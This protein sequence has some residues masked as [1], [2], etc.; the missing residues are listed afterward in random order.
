MR[1]LALGVLS[2]VFALVASPA[3]A[4]DPKP[5]GPQEARDNVDKDVAVTMDV[6]ASKHAKKHKRIFLDSEEDFMHENNLGIEITEKG[7]LE[8][9][10]KGISDPAAHFLKK[11][12]RVKGKV[13]T[14]DGRVY[15]DV[16]RP[17][18]IEIVEKK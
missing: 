4:D 18:Q 13:V 14:R 16:D 9:A 6:K 15:I 2:I 10:R 17:E 5:I 11:T 8:F 12:I 7:A 3:W 1:A